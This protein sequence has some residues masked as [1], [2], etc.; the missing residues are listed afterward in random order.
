MNSIS[1]WVDFFFKKEYNVCTV[2]SIFYKKKKWH[3]ELGPK[4]NYIN[5]Q[6]IRFFF[7]WKKKITQIIV[8]LIG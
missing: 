1:N 4:H 5:T 6:Y 7:N 2:S 8:W 3:D